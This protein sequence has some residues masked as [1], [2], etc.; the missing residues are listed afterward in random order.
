MA[1]FGFQG[2]PK[3]VLALVSGAAFWGGWL[4]TSGYLRARVGLLVGGASAQ[5]VPGLLLAH[6]GQTFPGA[7]G[8]K[9]LGVPNLIQAHWWVG[10]YPG[11]LAL[12]PKVSKAGAGLLVCGLSPDK[13]VCVAGVVPGQGRVAADPGADAPLT[14]TG[15]CSEA[16]PRAS[17]STWLAVPTSEDLMLGR[18]ASLPHGCG[19]LIWGPPPVVAGMNEDVSS[20]HRCLK[21]EK[22]GLYNALSF[23]PEERSPGGSA[24]SGPPGMPIVAT[25]TSFIYHADFEPA[26]SP[27]LCTF[28]STGSPCHSVEPHQSQ[29]GRG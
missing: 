18:P 16:Q 5:G 28:L 3:L 27:Q 26:L 24:L 9:A 14:A 21:Q 10:L 19:V 25:L 20:V 23:A 2:V 13:A 6:G 8:Y 29:R 17:Q 11:L 12:G 22:K 15:G 4:R 7:S 1:G